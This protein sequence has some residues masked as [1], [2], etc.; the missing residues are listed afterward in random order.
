MAVKAKIQ[1]NENTFLK[2]KTEN[3]IENGKTEKTTVVSNKIERLSQNRLEKQKG[4]DLSE[5]KIQEQKGKLEL[6]EQSTNSIK[7]T[8][9]KI[10]ELKEDKIITKENLN[11]FLLPI[12][13][14]DFPFDGLRDISEVDREPILPVE[15]K[16]RNRKMKVGLFAGLMGW[17]NLY[18]NNNEVSTKGILQQATS[19]DLGQ[20]LAISLQWSLTKKI[21]LST[22]IEYL[23]ARTEFNYI[24]EWDTLAVVPD[25]EPLGFIEARATRTVKHNNQQKILSVPLMIGISKDLAA[26]ELGVELGLGF[27]YLIGQKGKSLNVT[28]QVEDYNS[29][30]NNIVPY[31]NFFLSYQ[32]QPY[33]NCAVNER[34]ALQLQPIFRY[35]QHGNSNFYGSSISSFSWGIRFG[36]IVGF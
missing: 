11:G 21:H 1:R 26:F 17:S 29:K 2:A 35:Q 3:K 31:R 7:S 24:E 8:D 27:N 16:G 36:G 25:Y 15:K 6:T 10:S 12:V 30:I 13:Y 22:G 19:T 14:G 34:F 33:L 18:Q 5:T 20:S 23:N 4:T 9:I 32:V 28:G